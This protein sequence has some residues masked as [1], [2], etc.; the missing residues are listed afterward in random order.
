MISGTMKVSQSTMIGGRSGL[1]SQRGMYN[2]GA[3]WVYNSGGLQEDILTISDVLSNLSTSG[4]YAT[5]AELASVSGTITGSG[6]VFAWPVVSG[7]MY[8]DAS[9]YSQIGTANNPL[10][11]GGLFMT[12][13]GGAV[14]QVMCLN[15]GVISG[16]AV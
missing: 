3:N 5:D 15:D 2:W 7:H 10:H 14:Y 9:G 4:A 13:A 11:S 1:Q 6:Q 12:S 8:L 16:V